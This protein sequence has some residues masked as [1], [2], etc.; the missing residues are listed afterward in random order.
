MDKLEVTFK[1]VTPMFISGADQQKAELRA[2]SIKG[3]LRFWYRAIDPEYAKHEA[4][5]FGGAGDNQGQA[6]FLLSVLHH[7]KES[8][9]DRNGYNHLTGIRYLGYPFFF[10]DNTQR[11]AILPDSNQTFTL[12]LAFKKTPDIA[13]QQRILSTLWLFGNFGAL[14]SRARRGFGNIQLISWKLP[15][16]WQDNSLPV[17][18]I[19]SVEEWKQ[20]YQSGFKTLSEWFPQPRDADHSVFSHNSKICLVDQVDEADN[21]AKESWEYV[22]NRAGIIMQSFRQRWDLANLDS[23]Y[24]RV[25]AHLCHKHHPNAPCN[26][27]QATPLESAPERAAFGLPLSFRYSSLVY[28]HSTRRKRN[29]DPVKITP[30][31]TFEGSTAQN[32]RSA[33]RIWIRVTFIGDV[34]YPV[35]FRLDAPLLPNGA[36]IQHN[37]NGINLDPPEDE[38]LDTFWNTIPKTEEIQWE[39]FHE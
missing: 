24:F 7:L 16:S 25:K 12:R 28:D 11:K 9:W 37:T 30:K 10:R 26:G 33:S 21:N 38:I 6:L 23:D 4:R 2:P 31:I 29:G 15:D 8:N 34:A 14:G 17:T 22:L 18:P 1:I 39:G 19:T 3:C 35:F 13:D 27:I 36:K 20:H 5:I 32:S